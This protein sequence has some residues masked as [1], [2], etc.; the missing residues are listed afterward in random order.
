MEDYELVLKVD[1]ITLT[2]N[3]WV[4][5]VGENKKWKDVYVN[6]DR[7]HQIALTGLY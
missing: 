7:L 3:Y 2:D 4:K 5:K 1:A 6:D